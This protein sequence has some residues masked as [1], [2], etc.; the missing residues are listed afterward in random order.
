MQGA[1]QLA[2]QVCAYGINI[3]GAISFICNH[4]VLALYK[5]AKLS[6]FQFH[7]SLLITHVYVQI[8]LPLW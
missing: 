3:L 5:N 8:I 4:F 2:V 1:D 7:V 6:Y